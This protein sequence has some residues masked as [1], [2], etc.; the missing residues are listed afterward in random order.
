MHSRRATDD[1]VD[2]FGTAFRRTYVLHWYA[3]SARALRRAVAN[4][5]YV[6]VSPAMA[7]SDRAVALVAEVRRER[8][9]TETD[10]PIV[11][12]GRA[13]AE[14]GDVA[15]AGAGH[16]RLWDSLTEE[17]RDRVRQWFGSSPPPA[18]GRRPG[19]HARVT[20][21]ANLLPAPA[22]Q[23]HAPPRTSLPA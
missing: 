5:A 20:A 12:V 2:A 16:A 10:G 15:Q 13:P 4:G 1:V 17:T 8:V 3:G 19:S 6:S 7:R 23:C 11:K 21:P 14:P 22:L 9:L 18:R